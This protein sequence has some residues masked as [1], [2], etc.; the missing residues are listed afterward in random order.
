MAGDPELVK[1]I[2]AWIRYLIALRAE[3]AAEDHPDPEYRPAGR[4]AEWAG[5]VRRPAR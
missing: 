5:P 1:T 3:V 2:D 4:R